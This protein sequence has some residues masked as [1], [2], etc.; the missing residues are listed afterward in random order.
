MMQK[1]NKIL[2]IGEDVLDP[3]GGAFKVSKGLSNRFP[4]QV[5][6]TPISESAIVGLGTGLAMKGYFPIVEIMFGDFITLAADQLI[7]HAAKFSWMY[8]DNSP[9]P[10]VVRAPM[11]AYRGYGPTHSQSLEKHFLGVPG[12]WVLSPN[13]FVQPGEILEQALLRLKQPVLFVEHK[14]AYGHQL[15]DTFPGMK[16]SVMGGD[17]LFPTTV[18]RH[19]HAEAGMRGLMFCYGGIS[20]MCFE[21]SAILKEQEGVA[22]DMAVVTQLSPVPL[23]H[24]KELFQEYADGPIVFLE[25]AGVTAGWG[26][27]LIALM[28]GFSTSARKGALKMLRLGSEFSVIPSSKEL[29]GRVLLSSRKIADQVLDIF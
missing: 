13:I 29:E 3:Y 8:N 16:K 9:M 19:D 20:K 27:E 25:E 23:A 26:A 15:M 18:L 24:L 17:G 1:D 21:A 4:S 14:Y 6:T 22:M 28:Q 2:L 7:N 5:M 11:G 12:L 10:L